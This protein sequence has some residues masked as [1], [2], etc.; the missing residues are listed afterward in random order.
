M[1]IESGARIVSVPGV[2]LSPGFTD[3]AGSEPLPIR[4]RG[5]AVAPVARERLLTVMIDDL[6]QAL[7]VGLVADVPVGDPA[8]SRQ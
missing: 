8:Q 2:D 4:R 1:R 7:A 3:A 6:G 5:C